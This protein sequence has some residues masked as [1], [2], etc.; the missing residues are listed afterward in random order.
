MKLQFAFILGVLVAVLLAPAARADLAVGALG[1]LTRASFGGDPPE[2]GKYNS[3]YGYALGAALDVGVYKSTW[4]SIQ[5]AF[6]QRGTKAAYE[7]TG[8]SE[9]VDS[10]EV[11]LEYFSLPVLVKVETM[12]E[13]FYVVGG[14]EMAWLLNARYETSTQDLD[15]SAEFKKYDFCIDFGLGYVIPAGRSQIFLELRYY[16]SMLNVGEEN[17]DNYEVIEPRV[18]NK[19][20]MLLAGVLYGL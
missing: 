11:R 2:N 6:V 3:I 7:V 10:V 17:T 4:L 13:R 1:G 9:F 5:P 18:K 20:L 15:P 8:E 14:F 16:Q 19:G 12:G